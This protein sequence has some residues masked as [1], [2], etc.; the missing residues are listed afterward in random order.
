MKKIA[1][2]AGVLI[3]S[4]SLFS[5]GG[6]STC[7]SIETYSPEYLTQVSQLVQA[8]ELADVAELETE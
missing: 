7:A 5:C 8:T 6:Q 3:F 4:S 2:I 1:I